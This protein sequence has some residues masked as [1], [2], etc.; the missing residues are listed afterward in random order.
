M[1][2][3]ASGMITRPDAGGTD[4][5]EWIEFAPVVANRVRVRAVSGDFNY[6]L[7]EIQLRGL[8]VS[9]RS[10]GLPLLRPRRRSMG[11]AGTERRRQLFAARNL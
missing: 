5:N 9:G 8:P 4:K 2:R 6:S 3:V 7:S 10:P 11:H 1:A